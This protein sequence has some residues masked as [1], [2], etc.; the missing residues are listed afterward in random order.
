MI[1]LFLALWRKQKEDTFGGY[2]GRPGNMKEAFEVHHMW[3]MLKH[4][5]YLLFMGS[6]CG[7]HIP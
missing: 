7:K 4:E 5:H 1:S 2:V 3:H 6:V